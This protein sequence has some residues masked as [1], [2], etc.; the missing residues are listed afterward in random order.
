MLVTV[1]ID[2]ESGVPLWRQLADI[3]RGQI[4][5]G[6]ITRRLPSETTLMQEFGLA[7]GTV[8]KAIAALRDDGLV[9]TTPGV[10]TFVAQRRET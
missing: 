7:M 4:E 9:F 5:R 8:R 1:S 2:P 10:G 6:E 3:L